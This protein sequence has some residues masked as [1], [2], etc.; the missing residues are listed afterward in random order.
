M[1]KDSTIRCTAGQFLVVGVLVGVSVG[2]FMT[3]AY[4][5]PSQ[6]THLRLR[7]STKPCLAK[8]VVCS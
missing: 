5:N 7:M 8:K 2:T 6:R 1:R 3:S 4:G